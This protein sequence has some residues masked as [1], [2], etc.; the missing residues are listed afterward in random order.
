MRQWFGWLNNDNLFL[1]FVTLNFIVIFMV[2]FTQKNLIKAQEK[3]ISKYEEI[4][5][6]LETVVKK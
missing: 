5:K 3:L 1:I 2:L 4:L 6:D